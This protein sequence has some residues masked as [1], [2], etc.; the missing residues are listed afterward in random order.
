MAAS[1]VARPSK[2]AY[3]PMKTVEGMFNGSMILIGR[4]FKD[5]SANGPETRKVLS[6]TSKKFQDALDDCEIQISDAKWYLEHQLA[7]NK[8]RREAKAAEET[9]S[10]KRKLDAM[11]GPEEAEDSAET[12]ELSP[13]RQKV[14]EEDTILEASAP[15]TGSLV[16]ESREEAEIKEA[17][18]TAHE[19]TQAT[20]SSTDIKLP[21]P[22]PQIQIPR[23][24]DLPSKES[25]RPSTSEGFLKSTPQDTPANE[26]FNFESMFGEPSMEIGDNDLD[27]AFDI[28]PESFES[29][30]NL[31]D[32]SSLDSLLPGVESY[33]NQ[34]GVDTSLNMSDAQPEL[35]LPGTGDGLP[36]LNDNFGLPEIG[37]AFDSLLGENPFG[38]D[39]D[40]MDDIMG[41]D[42]MMDMDSL[43]KFFQ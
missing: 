11:K 25:A 23:P 38:G 1:A 31:D 15:E 19:A 9:A 3:D 43:D 28:N 6:Q 26:A 20:S 18:A 8:D 40:G 22:K 14:L 39:L 17:M 12:N 2:V 30:I 21:P 5:P 37:N 13:K 34:A 42:T 35:A 36:S 24:P 32:P 10:A 29:A 7:L 33:A 27:L 16:T 4:A 41:D